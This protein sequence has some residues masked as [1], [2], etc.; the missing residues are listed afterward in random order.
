[1]FK[2]NLLDIFAIGGVMK[3]LLIILFTI[4]T[5]YSINKPLEN[6][7]ILSGEKLIKLT[8]Q[9]SQLE[10]KRKNNITSLKQKDDITAEK[11]RHKRRRKVRPPKEGK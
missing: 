6:T 11:R 7:V 3:K 2:M 9:S 5:G 4:S 8:S 1:M 10:L